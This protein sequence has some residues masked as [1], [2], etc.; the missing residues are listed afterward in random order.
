MSHRV[1][2]RY[3][4]VRCP[5]FRTIT[6]R[7][8]IIWRSHHPKSSI[9]T[10]CINSLFETGVLADVE[11]VCQGKTWNIHKTIL[12]HGPSYHVSQEAF[13]IDWGMV[14]GLRRRSFPTPRAPTGTGCNFESP[15]MRP[16][17]PGSNRRIIPTT[18]MASKPICESR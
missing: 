2:P 1:W 13:H 10:Y 5:Q 14:Y 3:P 4:N 7:M 18:L 9:L 12:G 6:S 17:H 8:Y 16:A 11:I 15:A